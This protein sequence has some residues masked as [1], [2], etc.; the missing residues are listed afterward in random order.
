MAALQRMTTLHPRVHPHLQ[1]TQIPRKK[2]RKPHDQMNYYRDN[3]GGNNKSNDY[4]N[5]G[6]LVNWNTA[7]SGEHAVKIAPPPGSVSSEQWPAVPPPP[8][9]PMMC[10]SEMSYAAFYGPHQALLPPPHPSLALGFNKSTLTYNDLVTVTGNWPRQGGFGYVR[11]GVLPNGKEIA[12][13]SIKSGKGQPVMDFPSRLRIALGSA[14]GF[15]YLHE[16]CKWLITC[17]G[18]PRIIHRDIKAANILDYNYEAKARPI[19]MHVAEGR[20]YEELVDLRLEDNYNPQEMLRMS[21]CA[22]ACIRHSARRCPKMS[23][24]MRALEGGVSLEDL[25]EGVKPGHSTVFGSSGSSEYDG[26][27]TS[28]MKKFRI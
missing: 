13:K 17:A 19:L 25:S 27:Y 12:L 20:S 18:H 26:S 5:I 4:Y 6:Q 11:K 23:Q 28:E 3:S 14:K 24:I 21:Y 10:S 2:K 9:P 8:L 1:R 16:D 7:Q 22:A 15:A